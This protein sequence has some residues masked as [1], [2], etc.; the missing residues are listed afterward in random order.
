MALFHSHCLVILSLRKQCWQQQFLIYCTKYCA[1]VTVIT[2]DCPSFGG[3][4]CLPWYKTSNHSV[5]SWYQVEGLPPQRAGC[6]T[7]QH[8]APSYMNGCQRGLDVARLAQEQRPSPRSVT[9][10]CW[11]VENNSFPIWQL[12]KYWPH[13]HHHF[14]Y[15]FRITCLIPFMSMMINTGEDWETA[16]SIR[17]PSIPKK[18]PRSCLFGHC[19]AKRKCFLWCGE[20]LKLP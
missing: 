11:A 12:I 10:I 6:H 3:N 1:L 4:N 13:N 17:A 15:T 18:P 19:G 16:A 2:K 8:M 20:I 7:N 5:S 9:K 14:S